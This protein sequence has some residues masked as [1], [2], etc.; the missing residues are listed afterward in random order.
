M[1]PGKAVLEKF[2]GKGFD[3]NERRVVVFRGS[4]AQKQ[5]RKA[6]AHFDDQSRLKMADHA[7]SDQ[8]V[9]TIKEPVVKMKTAFFLGGFDRNLLIFAPEF[10]TMISQQVELHGGIHVNAHQLTPLSP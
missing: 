5:G 3:A 9:D 1:Q 7:V 2:W 10:W 8:G 4:L 6:A